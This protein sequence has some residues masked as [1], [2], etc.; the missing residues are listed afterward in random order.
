MAAEEM[1]SIL[2]KKS[3]SLRNDIR[4]VFEVG[5]LSHLPDI[6]D[7]LYD[8]FKLCKDHFAFIKDALT[9]K[10]YR[11]NSNKNQ[12]EDQNSGAFTLMPK[13]FKKK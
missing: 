13:I 4:F 10:F 2:L 1:P 9:L 7:I 11:Q 5:E 6:I 8:R 3:N 12:F